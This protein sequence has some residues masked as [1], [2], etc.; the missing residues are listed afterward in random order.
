MSLDIH[1]IDQEQMALRNALREAQSFAYFKRSDVAH[2]WEDDAWDLNPILTSGEGSGIVKFVHPKAHHS[3]PDVPL[4]DFYIDLMKLI[5]AHVIEDGL[6]ESTPAL[7]RS[8]MSYRLGLIRKLFTFCANQSDTSLRGVGAAQLEEF[9]KTIPGDNVSAPKKAVEKLIALN[10]APHWSSAKLKGKSKSSEGIDADKIKMI[11]W[12]DCVC[13]ARLFYL[14]EQSADDGNPLKDRADFDLLRFWGM[15]AQLFMMFPERLNEIMLQTATMK[16]Q[17]KPR[18]FLPKEQQQ[19]VPPVAFGVVWDAEKGGGHTIRPIHPELGP[20]AR[21]VIEVILEMTEPARKAAQYIMDNEHGENPMPIIKEFEH[22]RACRETGRI[23]VA[24]VRELLGTHPSSPFTGDKVWKDHFRA[25]TGKTVLTPSGLE[26][27]T[28]RGKTQ[29]KK[30]EGGFKNLEATLCFKTFQQDWL[31][32]FKAHWKKSTKQDWP[33]ACVKPGGVEILANNYLMIVYKGLLGSENHRGEIRTHSLFLETPSTGTFTKLLKKAGHQ[34]TFWERL[35]LTR[36]DT[37]AYPSIGTHSYRHFLNT[38]MITNDIPQHLIAAFSGRKSIAQNETYN[39]VSPEERTRPEGPRGTPSSK[40]GK[41]DLFM[42]LERAAAKTFEGYQGDDIPNDMAIK[43]GGTI[44]EERAYAQQ[45]EVSKLS[46]MMS[47][48]FTERG[49]CRGNLND[50]YCTRGKRGCLSCERFLGCPAKESAKK[51][52]RADLKAN[53]DKLKALK[54][55]SKSDPTNFTLETW[56]EGTEENIAHIK[57]MIEQTQK[58][59]EDDA[60][61]LDALESV[62]PNETPILP[63][64]QYKGAKVASLSDRNQKFLEEQR[65]LQEQ[66]KEIED[67]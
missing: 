46:A 65:R 31:R 24:Q 26:L 64:N 45:R 53:K 34:E 29:A 55:Q 33:I 60:Q 32:A 54:K 59:V 63:R 20:I 19:T 17:M 28:G 35:N 49:G 36:A 52:L 8:V 12:E 1:Q 9:C 38:C 6:N 58:Q 30:Y 43:I 4:P 15:V 48:S 22:I 41:V 51:L 25:N 66:K 21:R 50:D 5:V 67:A 56:I 16:A 14:L 10:I 44:D 62:D 23:S 37:G 42:D 18:E 61:Y 27:P 2:S 47:M 39:H 11:D 57:R 13:T 7:M 40:Y 3:H